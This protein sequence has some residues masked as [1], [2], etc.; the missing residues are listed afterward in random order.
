M[1]INTCIKEL[2]TIIIII[3]I[4]IIITI[5]HELSGDEKGRSKYGGMR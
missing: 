1:C 2:K 5:N 3:I 4:I